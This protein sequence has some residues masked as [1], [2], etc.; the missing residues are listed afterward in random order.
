MIDAVPPVLPPFGS[1][2]AAEKS[3]TDP[4]RLQDVARQFESL[5]LAQILKSAREAGSSSW[6]GTGEDQAGDSAMALAE[7][8]LAEA[9]AQRGGLGLASL[10]SSGLSR[11]P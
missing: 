11:R 3:K 9:L 7:E 10:I 8:H 4:A 1:L 2:P 5:L 6:L